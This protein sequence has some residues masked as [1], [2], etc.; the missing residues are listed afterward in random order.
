M[1][2]RLIKQYLCA[3]IVKGHHTDARRWCA[4][5]G[6][7]STIDWLGELLFYDELNTQM[8]HMARLTAQA[9]RDKQYDLALDW[10]GCF[11]IHHTNDE[12]AGMIIDST[13]QGTGVDA[14]REQIERLEHW[15]DYAKLVGATRCIVPIQTAYWLLRQSNWFVMLT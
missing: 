13:R 14:I 1:K 7:E 10:L 6:D 15:L 2:N 8:Q 9:I 12:C 5:Y 11:S 4:T 3:L